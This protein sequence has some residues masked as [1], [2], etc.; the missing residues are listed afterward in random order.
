MGMDAHELWTALWLGAALL[1]VT[2]SYTLV[3]TVRDSLF[4]SMLPATWLPWVYIWVGITTLAASVLFGQLT[5]RLSPRKSL[6]GSV[7]A[8]ATGLVLCIFVVWDS[9][10]WMPAIF[11]LYVNA[12]GL[13]V[14]SQF[15]F[16]TNSRSDP[17]AMKRMGGIVGA[18]AILGGL[19]GGVLASTLGA[20]VALRWLIALGAGLLALSLPML[21]LAVRERDVRRTDEQMTPTEDTVPLV[22][23][24]Y[25]RWLA[26]ATLCSVMVTGLLDYQFKVAVQQV[27]PDAAQLASFFGR[28]YI[29]INV[30][31]LLLQLLGTRWLLQRLGAGSAAAVLPI[32]LAVGAGATLAAPGFAMVLGSKA[33][34]Q[35]FR[36]SLNKSAVELLFFPLQPG[37]KRRAKAVIEAGIERVGDAL[38]G[39]LLLGAGLTFDTTGSALAALILALVGVWLIA[40]VRLRN[41]YVREL[42]RTLGRLTLQPERERVSLRELGILKETVRMLESPYERVVLQAID[43]LEENAPRLLDPRMSKLLAHASPRVRAR[44]L[45][46]AA[47]NPSLADQLHITELVNDPDAIVRLTALRVRCASGGSRPLAALDEYLDSENLELRAAALACLVEQAREDELPRIRAL[48]ERMLSQGTSAD[49]ASIAEILGARPVAT[50]LDQLLAPLLEDDDIKVRCAALRSA[51]CA[52][53]LEHVPALIRALGAADTETA[54]RAGLIALGDRALDRLSDSLVDEQVPIEVRRAIPRV[55]GDLPTQRV[56]T[57]LFRVREC[58]DIMLSYRILKAANRVRSAKQD[59]VFPADLIE[60]DLGHDVGE[61]LEAELHADSQAQ[62]ADSE[63]RTDDGDRAEQ[64]LALVLR[65]RTAQAFNRVFR[66]LGLVYAPRPMFSAYLATLSDST[67]VRANAAE[68]IERALSP[69]LRELVLPLLP[70]A[71]RGE[72][73]ELADKRYGL[74]Q[75]SAHESLALLIDSDDLWLRTCAL[76]VVGIRR[77]RSL[78]SRVEANLESADARVSETAAWARLA[79]AAS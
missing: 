43:L 61:F 7:L 18:G 59:L 70:G 67:R 34:D 56:V 3:K 71:R 20:W 37:I 1:T 66:R 57:A 55:L 75:M 63:R 8:A 35:T 39:I 62:R 40:C 6:V 27:Y 29:G 11:Y 9:H 65:E 26:G 14:V 10:T 51:G 33:W 30:F 41:G 15:W 74:R 79:L 76:Y 22:R 72:R 77:Q 49:R 48:I 69:S 4:L 28:F 54:A 5:Q 50:N 53:L 24:P 25:V 36:F 31:A 60:D 64:F 44:A 47:S 19:V 73:L 58:E 45:K 16:Y 46:Y 13:I 38:A 78:L 21:S 42:G 12:Y 32:G 23:V 68:Y 17:R 2:S 52:G